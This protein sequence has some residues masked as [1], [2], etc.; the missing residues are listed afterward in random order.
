ML[1]Q[2]LF[3]PCLFA[4]PFTPAGVK[5]GLNS[6]FGF[7]GWDKGLGSD[8]CA[9]SLLAYIGERCLCSE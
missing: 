1:G 5:G 4:R 6:Q 7:L 3:A 2:R 8:G 9:V